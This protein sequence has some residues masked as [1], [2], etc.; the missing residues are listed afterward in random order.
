MADWRVDEPPAFVDVDL[1]S[2][3][4]RRWDNLGNEAKFREAEALASRFFLRDR[5]SGRGAAL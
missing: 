3:S 4:H 5:S 2:V 1:P